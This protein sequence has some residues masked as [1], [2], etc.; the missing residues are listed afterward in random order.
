MLSSFEQAVNEPDP[1]RR[2]ALLTFAI[3]GGGP[4]GVELA[5]A[6]AELIHHALSK[7]FPMID[8]AQAR[9]VLIEAT[10][11]ILT[12]FPSRCSRARAGGWKAWAWRCG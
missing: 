7:D 9:V 5:G 12:A 8:T 10:D 1:A 2:R 11:K 3:I 4:T 6:F